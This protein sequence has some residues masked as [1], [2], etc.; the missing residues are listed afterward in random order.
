MSRATAGQT[1]RIHYTG[2]LEDGTTF[3]SSAGREPLEFKL[4]SGQIIPGLDNAI[5]GMAVG[6]SKQVAVQPAE[7][8]GNRDEGMIQSV[9]MTAIPD[10]IRPTVGMQ[11]KS[12]S[13]DG[14]V[15]RLVVTEV[16]EDSITVDANHP[17]AGRVL[18]FEVE[19]VEIA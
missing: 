17:L 15:V 2:K 12:E 3:D 6:E 8:Y 9:P 10:D 14:H 11:L 13:A 1:V 16:K 5:E 18:N 7:A 4:G 19:L